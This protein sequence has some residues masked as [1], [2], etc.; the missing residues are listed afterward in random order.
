ML[1]K[2]GET[3]SP[4]NGIQFRH[5]HNAMVYPGRDGVPN[6]YANHSNLTTSLTF[7]RIVFKEN[8]SIPHGV[9][10]SYSIL[11]KMF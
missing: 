2:L 11:R 6:R 9:K 7:L 5:A 10:R 8:I 1:C 4:I 3:I